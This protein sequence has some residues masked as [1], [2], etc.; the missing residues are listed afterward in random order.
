LASVK[1]T[2]AVPLLSSHW[3]A[4]TSAKFTC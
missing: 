4:I 1:H 3:T 2:I